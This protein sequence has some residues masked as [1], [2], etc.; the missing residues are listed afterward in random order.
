MAEVIYALLL[1]S[2]DECRRQ[3]QAGR[4]LVRPEIVEDCTGFS[5][6]AGTAEEADFLKLF[7]PCVV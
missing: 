7:W 1:A 2:I 5:L 4:E 6:G 3:A